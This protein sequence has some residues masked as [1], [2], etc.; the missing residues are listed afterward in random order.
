MI[1]VALGAFGAHAL[2]ESLIQRQTANLWQ[3]AVIYHLLHAACLLAL[4]GKTAPDPGRLPS[5]VVAAAYCW[6]GGIILFS[7]SLYGLALGAPGLGPIT[8]MGGLLFLA[9]WMLVMIDAATNRP[10][11][12]APDRR[13]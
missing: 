4:A 10:E 7:G 8:P 3:T 9:G 1:G 5:K 6:M 2:R 12:Q 11:P 13:G